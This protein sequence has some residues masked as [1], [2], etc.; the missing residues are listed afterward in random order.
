MTGL[1]FSLSGFS[2]TILQNIVVLNSG[3]EANWFGRRQIA[4]RSWI[5]PAL[6]RLWKDRCHKIHGEDCERPL[7]AYSLLTVIP[8]WLLDMHNLRL[9]PGR[10]GASYV[11]LSYRW[12]QTARLQLQ[13]AL[14]L[15]FQ[16]PHALSAC[17]SQIPDTIRNAIDVVKLLGESYMWV[18]SLC[19]SQDDNRI[20]I[21]EADSMGAI[22]A[23]AAITIVAADGE[24]A[25]DGLR[26]LEGLS[27]KETWI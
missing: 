24:D 26:G 21:R 3:T 14:I 7:K 23:N 17:L 12:S 20:K 19:I 25:S 1:Y 8:T 27:K 4:N 11:A 16:K 5:D 13:N 9:V 22:Y 18:D 10:P 15:E 2:T 6:L